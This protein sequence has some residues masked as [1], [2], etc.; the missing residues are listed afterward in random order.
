MNFASP[1]ACTRTLAALLVA[2]V[3]LQP[4]AVHAAAIVETLAEVPIQGLNPVKPNIMFTM[5]DSGSMGWDFLP[6]YV[7]WVAPGIAHCR[8]G[9]QCGRADLATRRRLR[10]HQYDPPG[11]KRELQRGVLR[12]VGRLQGGKKADGTD[13]PCEGSDVTCGAP[14]TGVYVNGFAGYPGAN[15]GGTIDLTT[16]YPDSVWCW[17][18]TTTTLEKQTADSNG[19]ICRRNGRS[20]TTATVSGNTTPAITAGYNYPNS[21]VT[22]VGTEKCK[23]IY[24]FSLNGNPYYYTINQVQ[25]CSATDTAGWGTTPCVSQWDPTTYK[26]VRYG[27]G[28]A[29][30]DAQAFTRVDIKPTGISST[31]PRRQPFRT[32]RCTGIPE[33]ANSTRS[34]ER[35]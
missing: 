5:D 24:E 34:T 18:S 25:F 1:S 3:A 16:G 23:F 35:A 15:S 22:C 28:A 8:D 30:F 33:F 10:L 6:D 9:I 17:K 31:A 19:S 27:T 21:S 7:A 2:A 26:Y 14:W 11:A 13:L 12:P 4:L 20:Y 32:H 29:T